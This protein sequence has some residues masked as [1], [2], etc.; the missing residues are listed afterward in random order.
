MLDF[1]AF[2]IVARSSV[3]FDVVADIDERWALKFGTSFDFDGL[4]DVGGRVSF[5]AWLA[6]FDFQRDVVWR[7]YGDRVIVEEHH[8]ARHSFEQVLPGLIDLFAGQFVLLERLIV[9]EH[10]SFA[11][12]VQELGIDIHDVCALKRI[13]AFVGSVKYRV[14]NEVAK[15]AFVQCTAFSGFDELALNHQVGIAVDLNLQAFFEV[16]CFNGRHGLI[17]RSQSAVAL[18][19]V[20]VT[21]FSQNRVRARLSRASGFNEVEYT[22]KANSLAKGYLKHVYR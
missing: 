10:E 8:F 2:N 1:Y 5:G 19:S 21:G 15:L 12:S 22:T 20:L 17:P 7:F 4:G 13:S 9:H 14:A 6:V 3:D 16:V 18:F 11:L